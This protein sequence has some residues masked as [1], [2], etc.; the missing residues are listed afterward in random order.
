MF[1]CN[2]SNLLL[3]LVYKILQFLTFF[4]L[5]YH[6]NM[7]NYELYCQNKHAKKNHNKK[8]CFFDIK[9]LGICSKPPYGYTKPF[10]PCVL[11]KFNKV[12]F[13]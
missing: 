7:S 13:S 10:Q 3:I 6:K 4:I 2:I 11:I 12:I 1:I 5:E 8:P 9:S